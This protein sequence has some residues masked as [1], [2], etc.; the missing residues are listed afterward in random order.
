MRD[1]LTQLARH[2]VAAMGISP[3]APSRQLK[4]DATH[5][6][7]FALLSDPA[8]AVARAYGCWGEKTMYGKQYVGVK[9]S[10]FLI[11][12]RGAV[13]QA[14]YAIKAAETAALAL[15]ALG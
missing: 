5:H 3:D 8:G 14:W 9:R 1:A 12:E 4:F 2:N 6:L 11:D 13:L 10:A 15:R 7:G